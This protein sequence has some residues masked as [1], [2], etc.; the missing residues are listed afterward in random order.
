MYSLAHKP[1]LRLTLHQ[2]RGILFKVNTILGIMMPNYDICE[3]FHDRCD[4]KRLI[5]DM[6]N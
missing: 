1:F 5:R 3:I 2:R 6:C 4:I